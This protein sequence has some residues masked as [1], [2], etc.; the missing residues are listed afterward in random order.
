MLLLLSPL[1]RCK[2]CPSSK[3]QLKP[4]RFIRKPSLKVID[5]YCSSMIYRHSP[6]RTSVALSHLLN[7][8]FFSMRV[9]SGFPIFHN[10]LCKVK[11][12]DV[13]I[14]PCAKPIANLNRNIS[15]LCLVNFLQLSFLGFV[16]L[17]GGSVDWLMQGC[18]AEKFNLCCP[19]SLKTIMLSSLCAAKGALIA[20]A[21]LS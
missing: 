19:F 3:S 2:H 12:F 7:I 20:V 15:F 4:T 18:E 5:N 13:S 16:C 11:D 14:M 10:M 17:L 21:P 1:L 9:M 6:R 8:T